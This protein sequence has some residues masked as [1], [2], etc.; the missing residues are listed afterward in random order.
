MALPEGVAINPGQAAGLVACG[1]TEDG[2]TTPAEETAGG[3]DNG[4]PE[5]PERVAGGHG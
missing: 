5:L 3:E 4:P 1:P 2:L